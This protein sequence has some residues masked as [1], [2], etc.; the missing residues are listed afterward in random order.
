MKNVI[1]IDFF[2]AWV[3]QLTIGIQIRTSKMDFDIAALGQCNQNSITA[4]YNSATY[5]ECHYIQIHF[6]FSDSY[7]YSTINRQFESCN[8]C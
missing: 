2:F 6:W 3:I 1:L 8:T 5:A 7:T 4:V